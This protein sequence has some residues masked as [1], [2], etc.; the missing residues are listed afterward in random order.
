[1]KLFNSTK[2]KTI[3]DSCKQV[4]PYLG[5]MFQ[6]P[7]PVVFSFRSPR[8]IAL[9]NLFVFGATDVLFL[10]GGKVVEIK[11]DFRPFTFYTPKEKATHCIELPAGL[12]GCTSVDD[13]IKMG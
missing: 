2:K 8:I 5:L 6:R 1:M 4:N 12:A 9:H 7:H 13:R 3:T 10:H 11:R